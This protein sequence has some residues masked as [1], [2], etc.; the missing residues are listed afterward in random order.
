[1]YEEDVWPEDAIA[2]ARGFFGSTSREDIDAAVAENAR[3]KQQ[4]QE[5]QAVIADLQK[6]LNE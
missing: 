1:M 5:T 6:Q 3:L 2:Y 4:I